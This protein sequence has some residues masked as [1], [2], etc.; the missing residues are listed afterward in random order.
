[1]IRINLLPVEYRKAETESRAS[2]IFIVSV[3][4]VFFSLVAF[5]LWQLLAVLTPLTASLEERIQLEA[6]KATEAKQVGGIEAEIK[7]MQG[8]EKA[9]TTI[10]KTRLL[11]ARKIDQLCRLIPRDMWVTNLSLAGAPRGRGA[12]AKTG[13]TLA[14]DCY[15]LGVNQDRVGDF[16][17]SLQENEPFFKDFLNVLWRS[18]TVE[19]APELADEQALHFPVTLD[20]RPLQVPAAKKKKKA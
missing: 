10:K 2:Y 14:M 7:A 20:L 5:Y 9:I 6:A 18:I 17:K 12:K 16:F 13:G 3:P 8:R 4:I 1:M 19:Q 11:W 15:L